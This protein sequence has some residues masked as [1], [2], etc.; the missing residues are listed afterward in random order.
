MANMR[1]NDSI[2]DLRIILR[3]D[4]KTFKLYFKGYL[5]IEI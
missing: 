3:Q 5:N 2:W 4:Y 1:N